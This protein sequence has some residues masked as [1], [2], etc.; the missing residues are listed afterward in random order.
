MPGFEAAI[1]AGVVASDLLENLRLAAGGGDFVVEIADLAQGH[2]GVDD[3]ARKAQSPIAQ[4]SFLDQ[5]ID[6]APFK[7]LLGAEGRAGKNG[8]GGV[9]HADQARQAVRTAR[10]GKDAEVDL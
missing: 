10:S 1:S 2:V 8:L 5:R 9:L 7:G 4:F 3:L 6:S